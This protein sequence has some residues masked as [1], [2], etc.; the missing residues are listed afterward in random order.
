[1]QENLSLALHISF[2]MNLEKPAKMACQETEQGYAQFWE[3]PPSF[4]ATSSLMSEKVP[5]ATAPPA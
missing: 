5:A 2:R 4:P 3:S 1:L